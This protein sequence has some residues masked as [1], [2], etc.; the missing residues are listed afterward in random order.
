MVPMS[1]I[2]SGSLVSC[3]EALDGR[4][5]GR[6]HFWGSSMHAEPKLSGGNV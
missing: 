1:V 2:A 5:V 3:K 6:F 4:N